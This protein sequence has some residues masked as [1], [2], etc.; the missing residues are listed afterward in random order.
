MLVRL[1]T[2]SFA[3]LVASRRWVVQRTY[4]FFF[5]FPRSA[6]PNVIQGVAVYG[7]YIRVYFSAAQ[8]P[9][10]VFMLIGNMFMLVN[11]VSR[12]PTLLTNKTQFQEQ[13]MCKF[14]F[15]RPG[16]SL[17]FIPAS[18]FIDYLQQF[19]EVWT[20][21]SGN[22]F[23]Q[24]IN[25]NLFVTKFIFRGYSHHYSGGLPL[26]TCLLARLLSSTKLAPVTRLWPTPEPLVSLSWNNVQSEEYIALSVASKR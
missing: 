2:A 10:D 17:T 4:V 15:R 8:I 3:A 18:L 21:G 24:W 19:P 23:C 13:S 25:N 16:D 11:F 9:T 20:D 6:D 12:H 26:A 7:R 1:L 14:E 22:T 5:G